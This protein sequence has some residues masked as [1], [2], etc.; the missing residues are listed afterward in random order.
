M[1]LD[2]LDEKIEDNIRDAN[3]KKEDAID[4]ALLKADKFVSEAEDKYEEQNNK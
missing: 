3:I 4:S 2:K 1:D